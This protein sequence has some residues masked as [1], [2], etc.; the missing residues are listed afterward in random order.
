MRRALVDVAALSTSAV[1][2]LVAAAQLSSASAPASSSTRE[3]GRAAVGVRGAEQKDSGLAALEKQL[4][5]PSE[6]MRREA[7]Q[8]LAKLATGAAWE[9]VI[10]ALKD[11]SPMV[12]DEAQLQLGSLSDAKTIDA[13]LGKRGLG[14]ADA[15]IR[16]RVAEAFGR[17]HAKFQLAELA[18]HL[19]DKSA[20]VRRALAWSI[21]RVARSRKSQSDGDDMK[22]ALIALG[23]ALLAEKDPGVCAAVLVAL[24]AVEADKHKPMAEPMLT[25]KAAETR[26]AALVDALEWPVASRFDAARKALVDPAFAVRAQAVE[27]LGSCRSKAACALLVERLEQEK[28][29]RLRWRIVAE[30]QKLSGSDLELEVPYWK[31]WVDALDDSWEPKTGE[32]KKREAKQPAEGTTVF[33][34]LPV[35][36]ER[37]AILVDFSGS[38]WEKRADGKTR[39]DAADEELAKLLKQLTP[40]TKFNVIPYTKDPIPWQKALVAATPDNVTKAL[41]FFEKCKE[42]GKGNVWDAIELAASDAEVDTLIVVT[43]GAPTGGHRWNLELMEPLLAEHLRFRK[44]TV[45]AILVDARRFLQER[46]EKICAATVAARKRPR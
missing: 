11:A 28:S 25:D 40:S 16:L 46:W 7:V 32:P 22:L 3:L 39:K 12:A 33:M 13:L 2:A 15:W 6:K 5:D 44:I 24:G 8:E 36:S 37:I 19:T 43:D 34:G 10:D 4:K 9:L 30:L 38:L 26:C 21:E 45:D 35:L 14:T 18:T 27:T 20:D 31:K 23:R 42:S 1:L 29:L 17:M 41:D